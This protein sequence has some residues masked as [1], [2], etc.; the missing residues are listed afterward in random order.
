[1]K[2]TT[3]FLAMMSILAFSLNA[4]KKHHDVA[5]QTTIQKLQ[6]KWAFQKEYYHENYGGMEYR[7]TAYGEAGDYVDFRTDNK[8]YTKNDV[9]LDTASYSLLGDDKIIVLYNDPFPYSDTFNIQILTDNA[10]QIYVK[11]FDTA[12]DYFEATQFFTK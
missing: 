9:D 10:L 1:M 3:L 6:A 5:A 12:P 8:V 4:C 11:Q 7:D 2:R